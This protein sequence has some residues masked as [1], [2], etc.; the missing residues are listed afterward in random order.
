M[1][2]RLIYDNEAEIDRLHNSG[3]SKYE[4]K[5]NVNNVISILKTDAVNI[6]IH[7]GTRKGNKLLSRIQKELTAAVVPVR[8]DRHFDRSHSHRA[9]K[10]PLNSRA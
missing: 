8:P 10:F 2:I 3:S 5:A 1:R 9:N 7:A 6:I 4:Y